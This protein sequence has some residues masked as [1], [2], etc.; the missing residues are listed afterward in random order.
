MDALSQAPLTRSGSPP[1]ALDPY[2]VEQLHLVALPSP[3]SS[4]LRRLKFCHFG[5]MPAEAGSRVLQLELLQGVLVA[6]GGGS[7]IVGA[8]GAPGVRAYEFAHI[9]HKKLLC[10]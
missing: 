3:A 8:G 5:C 2:L 1:P 4:H 6:P 7:A 10:T 9:I